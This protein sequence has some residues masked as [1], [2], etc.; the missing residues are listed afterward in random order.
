MSARLTGAW[1]TLMFLMTNSSLSRSLASALDSAFFNKFK[2]CRTDF[3]GHRPESQL[4]LVLSQETPSDDIRQDEELSSQHLRISLFSPLLS[5]R[6]LH[7]LSTSSPHPAKY[8]LIHNNAPLVNLN[9]LACEARPI[10]PANRRKGMTCLC[11][12]TSDK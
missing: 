8:R 1:L 7:F 11:S 9:C 2:M 6:H 3:S 5:A 4:T 10:P 12:L